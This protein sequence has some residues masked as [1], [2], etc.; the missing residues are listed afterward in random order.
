[1][2]KKEAQNLLRIKMN[3][4]LDRANSYSSVTLNGISEC[5]YYK[6]LAEGY[7]KAKELVG[8]I[9]SINNTP[10]KKDWGVTIYR[11]SWEV[12][13]DEG[14][15]ETFYTDWTF[16][17]ELAQTVQKNIID[18]KDISNRHVFVGDIEKATVICNTK[19]VE[20][21]NLYDMVFKLKEE[22]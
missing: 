11:V 15:C 1:M 22:K 4:A 17:L 13:D 5:N 8:N 10:D 14:C 9:D 6:G 7:K 21:L 20:G 19:E 16:D 2:T 3:Y 12:C 18:K